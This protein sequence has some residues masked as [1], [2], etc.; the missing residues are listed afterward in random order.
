MFEL[1]FG[2]NFRLFFGLEM[3]LGVQLVTITC[4]VLEARSERC[5]E[6]SHGQA[7]RGRNPDFK[8]GN[9]FH[10]VINV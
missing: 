9:S 10:R 2:D 8:S 3:D 7:S 4:N 6:R 1:K 5:A